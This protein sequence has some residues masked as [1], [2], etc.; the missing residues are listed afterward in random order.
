VSPN[1]GIA[2]NPRE[3][4]P[5]CGGNLAGRFN[6][7][8]HCGSSIGWV[9]T[10]AGTLPCKS[11]RE[12]YVKDQV[13]AVFKQRRIQAEE[14][15]EQERQKRIRTCSICS[16]TADKDDFSATSHLPTCR[17]CARKRLRKT[18][19]C[20]SPVICALT[21]L[22]AYLLHKQQQS[23]VSRKIA[24]SIEQKDWA[25]ALSLD[26]NNIEALIGRALMLLNKNKPDFE[27]A[28]KDLML[29]RKSAP[30]DPRVKTSLAEWWQRFGLSKLREGDFGSAED[31]LFEVS[32]LNSV[33][34][35]NYKE[36][37]L[38][39]I[40]TSGKIP[41]SLKLR[42]EAAI[43][44]TEESQKKLSAGLFIEAEKDY[45]KASKMDEDVSRSLENNL[46]DALILAKKK[47]KTEPMQKALEEKLS[48]QI[49]EAIEQQRPI[50]AEDGYLLLAMYELGNTA[51]IRVDLIAYFRRYNIIPVSPAL[52]EDLAKHYMDTAFKNLNE[53][54]LSLAQTDFE[55][56]SQAMPEIIFDHGETYHEK[57]LSVLLEM[58]DAMLA[59]SDL[60]K[61]RE[62]L[63][64]I[65]SEQLLR[66][67]TDRDQY[68][69]EVIDARLEMKAG[70]SEK[71]LAIFERLNKQIGKRKKNAEDS[72]ALERSLLHLQ[73]AMTKLS[74]GQ[75]LESYDSFEKHLKVRVK[76]TL[77]LANQSKTCCTGLCDAL[78]GLYVHTEPNLVPPTILPKVISL[79]EK[80]NQTWESKGVVLTPQALENDLQGILIKEIQEAELDQ[81]MVAFQWMKRINSNQK[82][83]QVAMSEIISRHCEDFEVQ[84]S[85]NQATGA[86]SAYARIRELN[87]RVAREVQDEILQLPAESWIAVG[88]EAIKQLPPE[89]IVQIPIEVV[90][91]MKDPEARN[92]GKNHQVLHVKKLVQQGK[93]DAALTF[94]VELATT[95]MLQRHIQT[96]HGMAF[97]LLPP[98]TFKQRD[99]TADTILNHPFE[100]STTEVTREQYF[101]V[102]NHE[103]VGKIE[104]PEY[105]VT[106]ISILSAMKFCEALSKLNSNE[107]YTYR[108]PTEEEWEYACRAGTLSDYSFGSELEVQTDAI[109]VADYCNCLHDNTTKRRSSV[110]VAALHPNNWD[111]FDM[112]GNVSEWCLPTEETKK[113]GYCVAAG[114]SWLSPARNC[115][116]SSRERTLPIQGAK[117]VGFRVVRVRK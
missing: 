93:F 49:Y 1:E 46:I 28:H 32:R 68:N 40:I 50:H 13:A 100:I 23:N 87:Q 53:K 97:K 83:L 6:K 21:I 114:G 36:Q 115:K 7:C 98:G 108:L 63:N 69:F 91:N 84:I 11:G 72:F 117:H 10:E 19:I 94:S 96:Y 3:R 65:R 44:L 51:D 52:R 58:A 61:C 76:G 47:P 14:Q 80:H 90:Q 70:N 55:K 89:I 30:D 88:Y 22:T 56:A 86:I 101:S 66:F 78:L 92:L 18:L 71:S 38:R 42:I 112:H 109:E 39:K 85:S 99:N 54:N 79:I 110:M 59:D 5:S 17:K 9:E 113:T 26:K 104:A 81:V 12:A 67:G 45:W 29:A 43:I 77:E 25:A 48:A 4:C 27:S 116:S 111:L 15:A 24:E 37:F 107:G 20:L 64:M 73:I 34:F 75:I 82:S 60:I 106:N 41:K 16:Y 62:T 33:A 31:A 8:Q 35:E 103:K 2:I 74:T 102:M 105:A 57:R 95:S